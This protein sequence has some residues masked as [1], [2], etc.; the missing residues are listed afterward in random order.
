MKNHKCAFVLVTC[1]FVLAT[2]PPLFCLDSHLMDVRIKGIE[3]A[4]PPQYLGRQ[5]LLSYQSEKP[6]RLVGARFAHEKYSKFH[7]YFRNEHDVFLLLLDVPEQVA[8]LEYRIVVDGLWINDPFNPLH[9]SD[10]F[11]RR[12]SFFSLEER[13]RPAP[14]SPEIDRLGNV[15]FFFQT[16]PGRVVFVAGDFN[17]WNPF[18][19]RLQET[20]E[21]RYKAT[22]RMPPGMHHYYYVVNGDRVLDPI[23]Q[24]R[25]RDYEG[26]PVS[27]FD[28]PV[29]AS[30]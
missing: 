28:L 24:K 20:E 23:N 22:L 30:R 19:H 3:Q 26:Y 15:T 9:R 13:P 6:V 1:L 8:T 25:S 5:V 2:L 4:G 18:W 11:G 12:Y 27:T 29:P 14:I 21:G 17:N 10:T 7:I 16:L